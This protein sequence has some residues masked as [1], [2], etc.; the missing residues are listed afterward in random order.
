[1]D[2][3]TMMGNGNG[4]KLTDFGAAPKGT[5]VTVSDG[6]MTCTVRCCDPTGLIGET[7]CQKVVDLCRYALLGVGYQ[8]GSIA[9]AMDAHAQE[10]FG[11]EEA[12]DI[13]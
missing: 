4:D 3:K 7:D 10:Y 12:D 5:S 8:P 13:G 9:E 6:I 11:W 2:C 1:M